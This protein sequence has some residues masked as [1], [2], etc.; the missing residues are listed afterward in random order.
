MGDPTPSAEMP[1]FGGAEWCGWAEPHPP[2]LY[3]AH[4]GVD[5]DVMVYACSGEG[6]E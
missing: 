6:D 5:D 4:G 1:P 2:H 3:A